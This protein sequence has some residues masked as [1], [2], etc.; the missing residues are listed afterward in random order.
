M[1]IVRMWMGV[2][3]WLVTVP[4]SMGHLGELFRCVL[5]LVVVVE[6]VDVRMLERSMRVGVI[7]NIRC[8]Q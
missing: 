3:Q 6:F 7:V 8:E 2:G 5:V 4:V 1:D